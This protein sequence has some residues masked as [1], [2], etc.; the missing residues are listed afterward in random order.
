MTRKQE[1]EL[2]KQANDTMNQVLQL[3]TVLLGANGDNGINGRQKEMAQQIRILED[4]Y[5]EIKE[6]VSLMRQDLSDMKQDF[7]DMK[8]SAL[9][10]TRTIGAAL[11]VQI[12]AVLFSLLTK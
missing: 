12:V 3:R 11:I 9:F 1:Q 7:S 10:W 4:S 6:D 5:H 8:K 2:S